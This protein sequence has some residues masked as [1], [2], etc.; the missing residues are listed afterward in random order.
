MLEHISLQPRLETFS[1]LFASAGKVVLCSKGNTLG[2][3]LVLRDFGLV[4][5][6]L[7]LPDTRKGQFPEIAV[8]QKDVMIKKSKR[9]NDGQAEAA[10]ENGVDR[11]SKPVQHFDQKNMEVQTFCKKTVSNDSMIQN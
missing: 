10:D 4:H 8:R 1:E 5:D 3:S 9:T 7:A 11:W 2:R 6:E